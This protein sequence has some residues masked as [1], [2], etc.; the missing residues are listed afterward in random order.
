[1]V[2]ESVVKKRRD[3]HYF[4]NKRY[5]GILM[6]ISSL[7]NRFGIGS[8]GQSA[9]DFVDFLDRTEQKYWQVLPLGPISYG[10]SPYQ[11]FSAFAGNTYFI[12]L[13]R[14]VSEGLL[15]WEDLE[16][17]DFGANPEYVDY[18]R[19]FEVRRPLMEKAVWAFQEKGN[20]E[21]YQHFLAEN[22]EWIYDFADYMAIKEHF[23]NQ[24]W[25]TWPDESIRRRDSE[26]LTYYREL[27]ADKIA[28]HRITQFLF[29]QQWHDL[30]A[31]ANSKGIEII[32]DM[33]IYVSADSSDMWTA[34]HFFKTDEAGRPTVVAGCPP[35]AFSET[36][37]LWGNPIYNWDAMAADGYSWWV[38]R[39]RESLKLYDMIRI[40]HFRGFEAYW[41][42][43]SEDDT[44][45]NGRWVKGPD[46]AL[47]AAFQ[48]ELGEN[49][50]IIAEDLGLITDEVI[51]LRDSL[52]LPGMK[53]LQF[54][55]DSLGDSTYLPHRCDYNTVTYTGTH[56][57]NTIR[58]WYEDDITEEVRHFFDQYSHRSHDETAS[59]AMIRQAW[60]SNSQLAITSMQDLLNLGSESRMNI[61]STLGTNWQWRMSSAII[62]KMV[63]NNLHNLTKLY[64]RQKTTQ[65][66]YQE[67][68]F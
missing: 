5:S 47:F 32:G 55:Y 50:P 43:P 24:S 28:Y 16:N 54:A 30:K 14:L 25:I 19:I 48:S 46:K 6:H 3:A 49:L 12:D 66:A 34:P 38:R 61:P 59:Q 58:G 63:E 39:M 37:Q 53:V 1:M 7:S 11:S 21:A 18:A 42:V 8:F 57:N 17:V 62:E 44:A 36:G 33:P 23:E 10:D 60:A 67:S 2:T 68:T 51:E 64:S 26:R 20:Q 13:E 41:E 27:L 9:Y 22:M 56:D 52:K 65:T 4:M 35:D 40:D 31:Y 15:S 45:L 29:F